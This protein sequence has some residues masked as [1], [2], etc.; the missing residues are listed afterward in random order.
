M[1]RRSCAT[2]LLAIH[3]TRIATT[4]S[5]GEENVLSTYFSVIHVKVQQ[6]PGDGGSI[7]VEGLH[8][9]AP[10]QSEATFDPMSSFGRMTTG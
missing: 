6:T 3:D 2:G 9:H 5:V 10:V 1:R 8:T 7:R 4:S